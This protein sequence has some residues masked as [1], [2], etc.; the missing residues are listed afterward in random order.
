MVITPLG[1]GKWRV[2]T[3]GYSLNAKPK[4]HSD[5]TVD[6][7]QFREFRAKNDIRASPDLIFD[8]EIWS[9]LFEDLPNAPE[10]YLVEPRNSAAPTDQT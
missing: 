9:I 4:D 1:E 2:M 7:I 3:V 8:N 10:I 5:Q 6:A